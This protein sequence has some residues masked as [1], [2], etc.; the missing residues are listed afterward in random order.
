MPINIYIM[1]I[2]SNQKHQTLDLIN[3][4]LDNTLPSETGKER[5]MTGM[6]ICLQV[7][8]HEPLLESYFHEEHLPVSLVSCE[9]SST[10]DIQSTSRHLKKAFPPRLSY[11]S[12]LCI[13]NNS[14]P[15]A[16]KTSHQNSYR[17][18]PLCLYEPSPPTFRTA[19]I[20]QK[21]L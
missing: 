1:D 17:T 13:P 4:D 2:K 8:C 5:H 3:H 11:I 21:S 9:V 10:H 16:Y 6:Q 7:S 19:S 18:S 15:T 14:L 20:M 12:L